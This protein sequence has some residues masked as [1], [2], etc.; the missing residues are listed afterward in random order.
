MR[1][2]HVI[3]MSQK[4]SKRCTH[5]EGSARDGRRG[6]LG[7]RADADDGDGAAAEANEAGDGA[8]IDADGLEEGDAA[9]GLRLSTRGMRR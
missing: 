2:S 5:V 9:R 1:I 3:I 7:A 4:V 8:H 6:T